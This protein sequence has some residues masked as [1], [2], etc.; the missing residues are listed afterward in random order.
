MTQTW[1]P[2]FWQ[3]SK[4]LSFETIKVSPEIQ[5]KQFKKK[6]FPIISE[7][8][9]SEFPINCLASFSRLV[10][11]NGRNVSHLWFVKSHNIVWMTRALVVVRSGSQDPEL[12]D[13]ELLGKVG[14]KPGYFIP[15]WKLLSSRNITI[16]NSIKLFQHSKSSD[17]IHYITLGSDENFTS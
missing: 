12:L 9:T 6:K 8:D 14:P 10:L 5:I 16:T 11:I 7:L 15:T 4:N 13:D 2:L 3:L 17:Y 1:C